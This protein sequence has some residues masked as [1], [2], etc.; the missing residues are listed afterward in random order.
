MNQTTQQQSDRLAEQVAMTRRCLR[1]NAVLAGFALL[2]IASVG[3]L[4]LAALADILVAMPV[5]LRIAAWAVFWLVIVGGLGVVVVWPALRPMRLQTIAFRIERAL[6]GMHNR[7]VSVVALREPKT[8]LTERSTAF[9]ERLIEQTADRM[10][11]YRLDRVANSRPV[12]RMVLAAAAT[13]LVLMTLGLA[14]DAR[15]SA[16]L[17]RLMMPTRPIPPFTSIRLEA[18]PGDVSVLQGKP[19]RVW[20]TVEGGT[21]GHLALRLKPD[22]GKWLNY[23]MER[24]TDG[25]FA[26]TLSAVNISYD[27]QIFGG[28]TWTSPN[29]ITMVR[30]PIVERLAA[31]LHM[32]AYMGLPEPRPVEEHANQISAP[33]GSTVQFEATVAGDVAGGTIHVFEAR[34]Q[35]EQQTERRETIWF[36]DEPPA[37]AELTGKWRWVTEQAYGGSRA[38]T[39]GWDRKPYGFRT[40]LHRL[41]VAPGE[42]F[43]LFVRL[44]PNDPPGRLDVTVSVGKS[45]HKLAWDTSRA[46]LMEEEKK[47]LRY[48]GS[49]P[50]PGA[51]HRLEVPI[52]KVLGAAP[53]GPTH[54]DGLSF[55]IDRGAVCFDRAGAVSRITRQMEQTQLARLVD[56]DMHRDEATGRWVGRVPLETDCHVTIE[57]RSPLGHPSAAMKAI[58]LVATADRPP[59]VLIERPGKSLTLT[60]PQPVPLM[61]RVFDDYGVADVWIQTG[62]KPR[63]FKEPEPLARYERPETSRLVV[64]ALDAK[65]VGLQPGQSVYYRVLARDRKGQQVA[66]EPFRLGLAESEADRSEAQTRSREAMADLLGGI[67]RMVDVFDHLGDGAKEVLISVPQSASLDVDTGSGVVELLGSDGTPLTAGQ[68]R[69]LIDRWKD[70]ITDEQLDHLA[71]LRRQAAEQRE[72]LLELAGGFD[73]AATDA[74]R[75]IYQLPIEA[76]ALRAMAER[77]RSLADGIPQMPDGDALD[78]GVLAR[79]AALQELSL[80][81]QQEMEALQRQFEQLIAAR[82][83]LGDAPLEAQDQY[84]SLMAQIRAQQAMQQL[85]GLGDYFQSQQQLLQQLRQQVATLREQAESADTEHLETISAAQQELDP[86]ALELVRRARELLQQ[87]L[88]RMREDRD[89]LPPAPWLPPGRREMA[90]P[91]EA[92]TPEEEP[93]PPPTPPD[94]DAIR[95]HLDELQQQDVDDWWDRPVDTPPTPFTLEANERFAGRRRPTEPGRPWMTGPVTPRQ[96]LM[97]HQDRLYQSLTAN[98]NRM[99]AAQGQLS[100]VMSQL[101]QAMLPMQGPSQQITGPMAADALDGLQQTLGSRGMQRMMGMLSRTA[102]QLAAAQAQGRMQAFWPTSM[103]GMGPMPPMG[104]VRPGMVL[105]IDLGDLDLPAEQGLALYRLPPWLRQPLVEGMQERGPE[106]YQPLIDAYYRSLSE[107][108]EKPDAETEVKTPTKAVEAKPPPSKPSSAKPPAPKPKTRP[109]KP[110]AT[111]PPA[112]KPKTKPP[113]TPATKP[114]ATKPKTKPPK[115]PATKPP[116]AKPKTKPPKTPATKPPATKPKTKPPKTPATKPPATKPK[117]KPPKTPATKPPA[118][119]PKTKPPKTPATKPPAAKP[120]TQPPKTPAPKPPATKPKTKPP[121]TPATKPPATKPKTQPPKT[122]A[123][124]P[125]ATKPKTQPPKPPAPKPPATKPKTPPPKPPAPKPPAAKPKTQ[126]PKTPATKPPATKPKTQPPKPPAPKPPATKPKTPPPKTP[127]P[128]PPATK[129]PAPKSDAQKPNPPAPKRAPREPEAEK[130]K[131]PPAKPDAKKPPGDTPPDTKPQP[132]PPKP[133]APEPPDP[134]AKEEKPA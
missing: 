92:D 106:A 94:L 55:E 38:H 68:I 13:V 69:G 51:W 46:P 110:P 117:T 20:A 93:P 81:Q 16:A 47:R 105:N 30:R 131:P 18:H 6:G 35:K 78:E 14:L 57:F 64:G 98:S 54:L 104:P 34:D 91:V 108:V 103:A 8:Q 58:P 33:A 122:P 102:M 63:A 66:S 90:Q 120:K 39:F 97:T 70:E 71:Q 73:Q 45:K 75:S 10:A 133:P 89:I 28:R 109:P 41:T 19:L 44:D 48:I 113:K 24:E 40:R 60:E 88:D 123:T 112:T 2:V 52:E 61:I 15:M 130:P 80:D 116:A 72:R 128:K 126:P 4:A 37:D 49:L 114:P 31:A 127:A 111:K 22:D 125:P 79:L 53:A 59:T 99:S 36:D 82:Q 42:A 65:R 85:G 77:A 56:L 26:F 11:D 86:E 76:E 23:P 96:M 121:K 50:D 87:R 101:E 129:Q 21:L 1:R 118:A 124:K 107:E 100:R 32:P 27:Y 83:T 134:K 3:W 119:K 74:D 17:Q 95:Q 115:P 5:P 9:V 84:A 25:R 67:E 7:L 132:E 43:F 12:G 29:R 62:P